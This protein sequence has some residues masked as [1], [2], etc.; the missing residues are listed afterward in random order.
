MNLTKIIN[1]IKENQTFLLSTHVN[2]D[3]DALCSEMALCFALQNL[4]KKVIVINEE[5]VPQRFE[6]FSGVKQVKS[7]ENVKFCSYD[8]AIILDCGD[9]NRIGKVGKLLKK[10]KLIIN[11]DHHITNDKF[12]DYNLVV[13]D[14]S[15]T[16]EVLFSFFKKAKMPLTDKIALHLYAGILTDTGS[17]RYENTTSLTHKIV[18]ELRSFNFSATDLYRQ[19]Y[20]LMEAKDLKMYADIIRRFESLCH[21]KVLCLNLSKNTLSRFSDNFDLRDTIFKFLRSI[22]GMEVALIFTEDTS[23][24]TRINLRS[25]GKVNVAK[26]S[27]LFDGGGHHNASGCAINKD[28]KQAR[29]LM[30]REVKKVL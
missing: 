26:L 5:A 13:P 17:F 24:N 11:I 9:L 2:P 7:F 3:P 28:I 25:A 22:K 1:Q 21:G 6:F 27:S 19:L 12:G 15:S 29:Q 16:G 23:N 10:D 14:A 30:L 18:S 4:G 20:E 8:V